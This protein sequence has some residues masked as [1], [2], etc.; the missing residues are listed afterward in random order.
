MKSYLLFIPLILTLCFSCSPSTSPTAPIVK[1]G[2]LDLSDWD[3]ETS[4]SVELNG[5][6]EFYFQE[7][8]TPEDFKRSNPPT[9]NFIYVPGK[10]N[11]QGYPLYGYGT[12]RLIIRLPK[13]GEPLSTI[14]FLPLPK[15]PRS[16]SLSMSSSGSSYRLFLNGILSSENGRVGKSLEESSSFLQ[17]KNIKFYNNT[18]TLEILFHFSNY[19]HIQSG[20]WGTV[21]L[22]MSSTIEEVAKQK[23]LLDIIISSGLVLFSLYHFWLYLIRKKDKSPLFFSI[24]CF[25]MALR[26]V[27]INERM[28]LDAFPSLPFWFIHKLEHVTI[29]SG[30]PVFLRFIQSLFPSEVHRK[31]YVGFLISFLSL[32]GIVLIFP[33]YIYTKTI[34]VFQFLTLLTILYSIYIMVLCI[35]NN[36]MGAKTFL[37][38]FVLFS[39]TVINDIL[40]ANGLIHT[41][42]LMTYGFFLFILFQVSIL[43]H[44]FTNSFA[45]AEKLTEELKT[46]SDRLEET[47][48]EL[49]ELTTN[50]EHKI[51]ERTLDLKEAKTDLESINHFTQ[52]ITSLSDLSEV[53]SEISKYMYQKY[54]ISGSWLFLPDRK[55]EYLFIYK[56]MSHTKVFPERYKYLLD[57]KFPIN[58]K[59]GMVNVA[60]KRKKTL[61]FPKLKNIPFEMDQEVASSLDLR[62]FLYVPLVLK[63]ECVGVLSF[64]NFEKEMYFSRS[65]IHKISSLCLQIAGVIETTYL[66]KEVDQA[67][68]Q[69]EELNQL[70]KSLNEKLDIPM[71]MEKVLRFVNKNFG[72]KHHALYKVDPDTATLS[73]MDIHFPDYITP[74]DRSII[75]NYK[76]PIKE[77]GAHALA[78]LGKR[79]FYIPKLRKKGTIEEEL[80]VIDKYKIQSF[81]IIPLIL[82]KEIIGVLDFSN[83]DK[84][85]LV[86]EDLSRLSILGEHL[87][88]IIYNANL[89]EIAE[90]ARISEKKAFE[91]LK[92]SQKQ[93]IQSEKMAA[94][95]NLISGIAH[96]INTPIGA[97][98]SSSKNL[99]HSLQTLL[100]YAPLLIRDLE[101]SIILLILK[102]IQ[103]NNSLDLSTKEERRIKKALAKT[104]EEKGIL[105]TEKIADTLVELKISEVEEEYLPLWHHPRSV[106]ISKLTRD[107]AGLNKLSRTINSAV[108]K[109]TKI[110][111]ALKTY[112]NNETTSSRKKENIHGGLDNVL[113]I[114][115]NYLHQGIQVIKEYGD[116]PPISCFPEELNQ[117][118][119]NLIFN[120]IQAMNSTGVLKI[121][122]SPIP[123]R[124]SIQIRIT[125]SG[126]GIS[127]EI[128]PKVFEPFFTT[129][130]AGEGSGLGL[131]ICKQIIDK[132]NGSITVESIPGSTVFL[133]EL[134][135]EEE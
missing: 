56:V 126:F 3:F 28:I 109:T 68:K 39:F 54:G 29:Y 32:L 12:Y 18:E 27:S 79:P 91:N 95:G 30:V 130:Q 5:N 83:D 20:I 80:F 24:F 57:R 117:V 93:L 110:V 87:A 100:T 65:E 72:I 61:Y 49:K 115:Q 106:E 127:P 104:L 44:R 69:T 90:S 103:P 38:G 81:L 67:Q 22:G 26:T 85:N 62:A 112:S 120:S 33:M 82:E 76:L 31:A 1:D 14:P 121:Q 46:K 53:F 98:K 99:S 34:N 25:F 88:G 48:T 55:K 84:M 129:K 45:I 92:S 52:V 124:K 125:D 6:W 50:L 128:L 118:W 58:G 101:D 9:P 60:F 116:L 71:I 23:F 102:L 11:T 75:K 63:N 51:Q 105:E 7:F 119:T 47:T 122:T 133:V 41:P 8:F 89:L 42:F 111:Y 43:S 70:I 10:W 97:I 73:V 108:D 123:E 13:K 78:I 135:I 16:L 86:K 59:N 40:R 94:L 4:G 134:P 114:Y 21:E 36:R 64:S 19:Q 66:L 74:E 113:I 15:D 17:N 132:H 131:Y 37:I 107:L 2:F 77:R 96:E 35:Q